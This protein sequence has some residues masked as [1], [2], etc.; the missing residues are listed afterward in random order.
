MI[1]TTAKKMMCDVVA[2]K[3]DGFPELNNLCSNFS[4]INFNVISKLPLISD[5]LI[6]SVS[7]FENGL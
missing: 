5:A 1:D 7:V 4:Q 2:L 3:T 6:R